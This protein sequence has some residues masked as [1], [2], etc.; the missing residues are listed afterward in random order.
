MS[1]ILPTKVKVSRNGEMMEILNCKLVTLSLQGRL[2]VKIDKI[3]LF[4]YLF[5]SYTPRFK[6]FRAN[7]FELYFGCVGE[8]LST[9][10]KNPPFPLILVYTSPGQKLLHFT[11]GE[12]LKSKFVIPDI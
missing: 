9:R 6:W 7:V 12:S 2:K 5:I 8:N 10:R 1:W 11:A 4:I 3:Y